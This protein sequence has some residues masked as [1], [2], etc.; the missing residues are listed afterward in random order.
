MI[1]YSLKENSFVIELPVELYEYG[2]LG[3][4]KYET[5]LG[6]EGEFDKVVNSFISDGASRKKYI[7]IEVDNDHNCSD[8]F[9]RA[10]GLSGYL[11]LKYA[12]VDQIIVNG[13][14]KYKYKSRED[15]PYHD[16][17][18]GSGIVLIEW[19][20]KRENF[21]KKT[22]SAIQE[23]SGNIKKFMENDKMAELID[24]KKE[25]LFL[26]NKQY[27]ETERGEG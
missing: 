7:A 18:I 15:F 23:L 19:S 11:C 8:G 24:N 21:L 26:V 5:R 12:V 4:I 1:S 3:K 9:T 27:E 2:Y 17:Y 13:E 16:F 25:V 22:I 20:E 6:V 14:Y 10:N